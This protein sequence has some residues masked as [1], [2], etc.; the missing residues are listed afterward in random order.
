MQRMRMSFSLVLVTSAILS[1]LIAGRSRT[2]PAPAG[3]KIDNFSLK[4]STGKAFALADFKDK[5]AIVVLFIGTECPINNNYM[6]RLAELHKEYA[7]KG[8]QFLAVNAN[9]QDNVERIAKHAKEYDLPFPVLKDETAAVADRFGAQR[10]P[11]VF[12]LD[13][14][15]VVRYQGRIDD[16]FGIGFQ[17]PK[18]NRRDLAEA[19]DSVLAGKP[20]EKPTTP[21]AGCLIGRP[22]KP[23]SDGKVVFAKHVAPI[24]QRHCQECHR[25]GMIGPMSLLSYDDAS[26]WSATIQEVVQERRMPPWHA[27]P[28]VGKFANDRSLPKEDRDTLLAWIEQGCAQGDA[29][30]LPPA[31]QFASN[32]WTIGKPDLVVEMPTSFK[33]PAK[34]GKGGVP[35]KYFIVPTNFKEDRWVQAV[36]AKPGNRAVVHHII[37]Y[38]RTLAKENP[39]DGI[40]DGMLAAQAPGELPTVL[41]M[42]SA[43]KIPKGAAFVFQM[44]YTP[45][46]TEQTDRSS[47]GIIFAKEP[48]K[49]E[50]RTRAIAT[51]QFSI[52]PG[53]ASYKTVSTSNFAQDTMLFSFL[54]HMHLRGKSFEYKAHYP[55]GK[56]ETLL[57]VPR[58]EFGW[59][60]TYRLQTPLKLPAGTRIEC[61]AF[62]DNS[63]DNPNNPDATATVRWGEQTWQ[64]MMIGFVDYAIANDG[65]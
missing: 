56:S 29:K 19:L 25:P 22:V 48:P 40:G 18:A 20:V 60:A 49:N 9:T 45:N 21:V 23:K 32:E 26:A 50:I 16:Q 35:Y 1:M 31:R 46:G 61:T 44:H 14:G 6:P 33:V 41:P 51:R 24:L 3:K 54:P 37:V 47:V 64:E 7:E 63:A 15:R 4:D 58:Y 8:V 52:P 38:A 57:S 27:D 17:R 11:E 39:R 62:F 59:Q 53:D 65:K 43:K 2:D 55:D 10:T 5:K 12:V 36:E 28:K 42:G 30:D 34:A 13:G